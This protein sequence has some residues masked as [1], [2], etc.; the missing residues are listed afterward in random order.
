MVSLS[1]GMV[2]TSAIIVIYEIKMD[3]PFARIQYRK[4]VR[5]VENLTLQQISHTP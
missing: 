3:N 4:A 1:R 5:L 2:T